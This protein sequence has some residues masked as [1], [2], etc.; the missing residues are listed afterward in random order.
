MVKSKPGI[1][2]PQSDTLEAHAASA[3]LINGNVQSGL[4]RRLCGYAFGTLAVAS[5]FLF[6]DT[7]VILLV[8]QTH[9][10]WVARLGSI[11]DIGKAENYLIPA[12]IIVLVSG[13][14]IRFSKSPKRLNFWRLLRAHALFLFTAVAV[15]G[16]ITDIIK[17]LIGRARPRLM[18]EF[19]AFH[20]VPLTL[21]SVFFSMPSGHATTMG[22][23]TCALCLWFPKTRY[24]VLPLGFVLASTRVFALAH[25]PTDVI[26][27]FGLGAIY[28]L[29][30]A[31]W[32]QQRNAC[33]TLINARLMPVSDYSKF[34]KFW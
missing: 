6:V 2:E 27:G 15:S 5:A 28:T 14:F 26:I 7:Q 11:S 29:F 3:N 10:P 16:I 18:E 13:I 8:K 21:K 4:S 1:A 19:G 23:V 31:H 20:F 34:R 12:L 9:E 33:F 32:L 17:P 25:Y 22:A 30:L 24:V